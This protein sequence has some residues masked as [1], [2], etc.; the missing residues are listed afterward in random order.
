[1][2][3]EHRLTFELFRVPG[4]EARTLNAILEKINIS[5]RSHE[6]IRRI[7]I[8]GLALTKILKRLNRNVLEVDRA[9]SVDNSSIEPQEFKLRLNVEAIND[10]SI[11]SPEE[12]IWNIVSKISKRDERKKYLRVLCIHGFWF[13]TLPEREINVINQLFAMDLIVERASEER[14]IPKAISSAKSK[15]GGLMP[16]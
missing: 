8:Q 7:M 2:T 11:K 15:L 16:L 9:I 10:Q 12:E 6:Y 13:E 3:A 5:K 1:M 4:I 14:P